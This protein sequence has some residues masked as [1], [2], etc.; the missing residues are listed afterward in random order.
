MA[1]E[2][3]AQLHLNI[4]YVDKGEL[5]RTPRSHVKRGGPTVHQKGRSDAQTPRRSIHKGSMRSP[6]TLM[7]VNSPYSATGSLC[8]AGPDGDDM[9][10]PGTLIKFGQREDLLHFQ[11][12]GLLYMNNLP[13]FWKIEDEVFRG[14]P[15]GT[16]LPKL[17]V[18]GT[19]R[20]RTC[21]SECRN[22]S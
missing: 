20:A 16:A 4:W 13:Y 9:G 22:Q 18:V 3:L 17:Q 15:F 6:G 10:E 7:G 19:T 1:Q 12:E 11:E 14:D 5:A 8:Y 21:K 2:N